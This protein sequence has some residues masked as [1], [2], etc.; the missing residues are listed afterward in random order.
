[1]RSVVVLIAVAAALL[2]VAGVA[3]RE[4]GQRPP[5]ARRPPASAL[6]D[7]LGLFRRALPGVVD[8]MARRETGP[9]L[10]RAGLDR[11]LTPRDIASA[12]AACVVVVLLLI[13][14]FTTA[15]PA[16][17]LPLV[18]PTLFWAAAEL[19]LLILQRRARLRAEQL[20]AAL[21]DALDLLRACLTAGLSLRRSLSLVAAHCAEPAAGEFAGVAA[22]TAFGIPQSIALDGLA[23]RNPHP[24]VRALVA[25]IRQA[26]RDGSPLA[27]VIAAQARDARLA[28]NRMIL[29]RG[30]R[31]GPKIQL[32]V[33][34]V[35]VPGALV[36]LAAVVIA[37]IAR[38]EIRLL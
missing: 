34:A 10:M 33:S 23:A 32:V 1:M 28:H 3:S 19:P 5:R 12:R 2:A 13:P 27:P 4:R 8:V 38:G 6:L 20:R 7:L 16:R 31:A 24:E 17:M 26:E 35:V 25:A 14:R 37:A 15:L 22:E 18:I 36:G 9:L 11:M 29:E 30:A 21:P